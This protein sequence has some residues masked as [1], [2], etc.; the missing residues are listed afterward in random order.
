M[1][2]VYLISFFALVVKVHLFD[3]QRTEVVPLTN[4]L[5]VLGLYGGLPWPLGKVSLA[6]MHYGSIVVGNSQ[7]INGTVAIL[8]KVVFVLYKESIH[9]LIQYDEKNK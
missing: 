1:N 4:G 6:V 7:A 8:V 9:F 3:I 2:L 5:T